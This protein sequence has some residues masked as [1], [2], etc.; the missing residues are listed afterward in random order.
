MMVPLQELEDQLQRY[1]LQLVRE[2]VLENH[3]EVLVFSPSDALAESSGPAALAEPFEQSAPKATA[4]AQSK[5]GG[6][7]DLP[8]GM[9]WPLVNGQPMVFVAQLNLAETAPDD[10]QR[11]LP[12]HGMLY[13]FFGNDE[14]STHMPHRVIYV[15]NPVELVSVRPSVPPLYTR[16]KVHLFGSDAELASP[17]HPVGL[18][19]RK[20]LNIPT[21]PYAEGELNSLADSIEDDEQAESLPEVYEMLAR[22]VDGAWLC[23]MYG[24]PEEQNGDLEY[25]AALRIHAD[26]PYD[27]FTDSALET[28]TG[29]FQSADR[30]MEA[31]N[32][33]ML[34]LEVRSDCRTGFMWGNNGLIHYY[35][36]RDDLKNRRFDRT[37]CGLTYV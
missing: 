10:P 11:L 3:R 12:D 19:P 9:D 27:C 25:E 22:E 26:Q 35:I 8:P 37:F 21:L 36:D 30:A 28:L 15:E 23:K 17:F 5:A 6:D 4:H 31:V 16:T 1:E 29:H 20:G 13:F 14:P 32:N 34:L 2:Y 33:A 18:T 24:Y 7:P